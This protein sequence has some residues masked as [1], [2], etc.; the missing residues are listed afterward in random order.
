MRVTFFTKVGE[1]LDK[2]NT[3]LRHRQAWQKPLQ[4]W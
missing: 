3:R 4:E 1:H 2:W